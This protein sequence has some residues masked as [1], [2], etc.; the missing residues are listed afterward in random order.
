MYKV[1]RKYSRMSNVNQLG[2]LNGLL[3]VYLFCC[4]P[5][6][7]NFMCTVRNVT[8]S[9]CLVGE[10]IKLRHK[11]TATAYWAININLCSWILVLE[12]WDYLILCCKSSHF[13]FYMHAC[14]VSSKCQK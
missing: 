14:K 4:C 7:V 8:L 6:L 10:N 5:K 2:Y 1:Q 11:L 13:C 3:D 12:E 9:C